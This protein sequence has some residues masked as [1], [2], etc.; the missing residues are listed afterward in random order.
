MFSTNGIHQNIDRRKAIKGLMKIRQEWE[1]AA[2]GVDLN[3][4]QGNVGMILADVASAFGLTLEEQALA[5]GTS[6]L[7]KNLI[8]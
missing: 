1:E 8:N 5:L 3:Q 4:V 2:D 7:E 6:Y